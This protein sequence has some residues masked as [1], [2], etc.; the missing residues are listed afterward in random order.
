LDALLRSRVT[1]PTPA[2]ALALTSIQFSDL[3]TRP[4]A[5]KSL[6]WPATALHQ[7]WS[8]RHLELVRTSPSQG[9]RTPMLRRSMPG[10]LMAVQKYRF[11]TNVLLQLSSILH[12][13]RESA[14]AR[15]RQRSCRAP[16]R[17]LGQRLRHQSQSAGRRSVAVPYGSISSS[18]LSD[19]DYHYV[20]GRWLTRLPTSSVT[21]RHSHCVTPDHGPAPSQRLPSMYP[22]CMVH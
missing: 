12:R 4:W 9:R 11:C 13:S 17:R 22:S 20:L 18:I 16:T 14:L 8:H 1:P 15:Q 2:C 21:H 19:T 3:A 6:K 10:L 7:T 5:D